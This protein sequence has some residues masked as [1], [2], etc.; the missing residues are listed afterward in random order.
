[1]RLLRGAAL[2]CTFLALLPSAAHLFELHGKAALD[3]AT[4]FA[5]QS[6]YAG[7]AWFAVA[8]ILALLL[9]GW[10]GIRLLRRDRVAGTSALLSSALIA[11][12]LAIFFTAVFPANRLTRNWT[13][14]AA[15]WQ[16]MRGSW[17]HGHA[18]SAILLMVALLLTIVAAL[19]WPE[20]T[21]D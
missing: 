12:S 21:S 20:A 15:G 8:V 14:P 16:Q 11:A 19:H 6:V 7:W 17:E 10:L 18:L 13:F 2:L 9:N 5:V 4:Y 1:M 3:P